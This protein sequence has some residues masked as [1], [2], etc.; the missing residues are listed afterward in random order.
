MEINP[1]PVYAHANC[2]PY[3][4]NDEIHFKKRVE[5]FTEFY[6]QF[7]LKKDLSKKLAETKDWNQGIKHK[8]QIS[9]ELDEGLPIPGLSNWQVI[10]TKGH[11]QSHISLYRTSDQVLIYGVII[12]SSIHQPEY[13]WNLLYTRKRNAQSH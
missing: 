3:L 12:S 9:E 5:F 10:E 13:S 6:Q 11:A 2:R 1:V 4:T 7:G 8:V